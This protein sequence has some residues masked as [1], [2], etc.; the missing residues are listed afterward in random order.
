MEDII[1][2]EKC[3]KGSYVH[4]KGVMDDKLIHFHIFPERHLFYEKTEMSD[5][6]QAI[7]DYSQL[8]LQG[9]MSVRERCIGE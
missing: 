6:L 5:V 9:I 1:I 2:V 8:E 4:V 7:I 3:L